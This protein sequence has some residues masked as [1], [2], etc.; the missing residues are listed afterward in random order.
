MTTTSQP[1]LLKG[2]GLPDYAA[3]TPEQVGLHI[4]ALLEDLEGE[5]QLSTLS[6]RLTR[7]LKSIGEESMSFRN[8]AKKYGI[9]KTSFSAAEILEHYFG[10]LLGFRIEGTVIYIWKR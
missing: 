7:Y 9:P 1:A 2:Q 3:I 5:I 6:V 8:F 4:P 10:D